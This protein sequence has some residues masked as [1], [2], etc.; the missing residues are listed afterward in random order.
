M[1]DLEKPLDATVL[2]IATM[3]GNKGHVVVF[4]GQMLDEVRISNVK[5]VYD[6]ESSLLE[7]LLAGTT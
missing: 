4:Y 3:Q 5:E 1:Q 2:A 7:R 6:Y